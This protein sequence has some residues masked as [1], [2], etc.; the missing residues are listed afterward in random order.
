M[1]DAAFQAMIAAG[2]SDAA[3]LAFYGQVA[4]SELLLLVVSEPTG[5]V[6]APLVF[7]LSDGPVVLA[8]D[9]EERLS[10][11]TGTISPYAAL[12][13]RVIA[14]QLA[15]QGTSLGLNFGAPS[16]TL[17]PPEALVW[18]AGTLAQTPSEARDVPEAFHLPTGLPEAL[19]SALDGRLARAAGIAEAALLAEVAYRGG[20]RGHMLAFVGAA[21]GAEAALAR[22]ANEALVFSGLD[23]G[24]MDVVFLSADDPAALSMARVALR[25][26]LAAKAAPAPARQAPGTDP[27]RPPRL[28]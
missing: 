16:E 9:S 1:I 12:P 23:A 14:T 3:R 4:D 17:L 18:L 26:D 2:E 19:I 10:G 21:A 13:G 8:F 11:F 25:F 22:S 27:T 5:D 6:V 15:G 24:E 28:R 20:R 7:R